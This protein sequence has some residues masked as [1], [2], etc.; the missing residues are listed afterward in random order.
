MVNFST[1]INECDSSPCQHGGKCNNL[2]NRYTCTCAIGYTGL[3]CETGLQ[4][5][6]VIETIHAACIQLT[7]AYT[8]AM[9]VRFSICV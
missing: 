8:N 3:N 6:L 1:E 5:T 7:I 9:S 2:V 4:I